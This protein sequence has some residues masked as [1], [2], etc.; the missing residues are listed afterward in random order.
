MKLFWLVSFVL[1]ISGCSGSGDTETPSNKKPTA[2]TIVNPDGGSTTTEVLDNGNTVVTVVNPD[3]STT[4]TITF[5]DGSVS[6]I[7]TDPDGNGDL[8][9]M[10]LGVDKLNQ[11]RLG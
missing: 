10:K 2:T 11:S 6:I 9:V 7:T 1:I 8:P 5:P 4:Q 3:G